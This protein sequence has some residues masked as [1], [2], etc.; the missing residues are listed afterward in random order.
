MKYSTLCLSGYNTLTVVYPHSK[1]RPDAGRF[2]YANEAALTT[3][4]L[5]KFII[6]QRSENGLLTIRPNRARRNDRN[7]LPAEYVIDGIAIPEIHPLFNCYILMN[8]E[9]FLYNRHLYAELVLNII[10]RE[11]PEY[12][13]FTTAF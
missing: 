1:L 12:W 13:R 10:E 6:T 9:S 11:F 8:N 5:R 4:P 3:D 2:V 7:K